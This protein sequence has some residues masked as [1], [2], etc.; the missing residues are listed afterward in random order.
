MLRRT[1]GARFSRA[2]KSLRSLACAAAASGAFALT[3]AGAGT[4]SAG[5]GP[6]PTPGSDQP[7][8]SSVPSE[9]G[10]PLTARAA[11]AG[12]CSDAYQIGTVSY[13][14]RGTETIASVKQF[15]SPRCKENYGYVW[16]WKSFLDK[17][18][19]FDL[20]VG[21]WDYDRSTLLGV[22]REYDSLS[23]EFWGNGADTVD[24][25]TSGDGT[26]T[27]ADEQG[28]YSARTS[29]RC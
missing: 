23:Q 4:A 14:Y 2:Q 21:V 7:P 12:V 15:Y 17:K 28:G 16:V 26:L 27:I 8:A 29:K 1:N 11:A 25:C 9:A 22:R 6:T 20:Q 3:L 13:A 19:K 24:D 5:E 18:I 10:N